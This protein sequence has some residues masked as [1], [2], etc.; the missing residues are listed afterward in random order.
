LT[1]TNKLPLMLGLFLALTAAF[2][3]ASFLFVT[4]HRW[5][6][7]VA[8]LP[9][10]VAL[11]SAAFGGLLLGRAPRR[12]TRSSTW[13]LVLGGLLGVAWLGAAVASLT[14]SVLGM[15][16]F[17]G[18]EVAV[19]WDTYRGDYLVGWYAIRALQ[20]AVVVGLVGGYFIASGRAREP[21]AD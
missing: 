21:G 13:M 10:I 16:Y 20:L 11:F 15:N 5:Y 7:A 12:G 9:C 1:R 17:H 8:P 19:G 6:W 3:S 18:F 4:D 14:L 2:M